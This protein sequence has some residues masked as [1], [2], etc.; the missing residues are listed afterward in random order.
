MSL[1]SSPFLSKV[2]GVT[3]SCF[4]GE[5]QVSCLKIS[6]STCLILPGALLA[7]PT[8][9]NT[10]TS[11][12][13]TRGCCMQA[14]LIAVQLPGLFYQG[15]HVSHARMGVATCLIPPNVLHVFPVGRGVMS[16]VAMY[17][18]LCGVKSLV[19]TSIINIPGFPIPTCLMDGD[20]K[21][22]HPSISCQL[23]NHFLGICH[24]NQPELF[25][26]FI[27]SCT[28]ISYFAHYVLFSS[29]LASLSCIVINLSLLGL[30]V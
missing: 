17:H 21:R 25:F 26:N 15:L 2:K 14:S 16:I 27:C 4:H 5:Q 11:F 18:Y 3:S 6:T 30:V 7:S 10:T 29:F 23:C 28:P 8:G 12:I 9:R 1:V 13:C 22:P 20:I 24:I 19:S